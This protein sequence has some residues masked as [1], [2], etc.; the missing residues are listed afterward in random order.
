[1]A[2]GYI[3]IAIVK[4]WGKK[5]FNPYLVPIQGSISIRSKRLYTETNISESDKDIFI[6][7]GEIQGENET[8]KIFSFVDK[9]IKKRKC[10]CIDSKNFVPTAAGLASSASAYC[11]LTKA[12]NDFFKLNLNTEEMAKI[13][14]MGSGSAGR[15]FYNIAAFDKN[16]KIYELKTELNLSM[17]AIVLN[18]K[19]KE[20]SSRNAMEISKNSPI[21]PMWVKRANEDFE[22]MKSALLEN[23]F[24]KIGNIMEKNTIIM[25]NTTF[26]SNPS[27]SFL[28]KETYFVIK[29][30]KRLR[31]KGINI[32][33]TMDAGPN[34]KILYLKEDEEKVL[35][36]LNK[37]FEGKILLC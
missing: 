36:E 31:M 8:K 4:Y 15:S 25:H 29:I 5:E 16:G 26:R 37:Y 7:N 33:T 2:R 17:L 11:T 13:S 10:I 34:V 22:K 30:V 1:M 21:Y 24:I 14:T 20:I 9:V 18:D 32:F 23:D 19:K 27:F 3:N 28:T 12:L 6:L 35:K